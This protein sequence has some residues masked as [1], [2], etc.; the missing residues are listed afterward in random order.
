MIDEFS[1]PD[2]LLVRSRLQSAVFSGRADAL[3]DVQGRY[4]AVDTGPQSQFARLIA[5]NSANM[6]GGFVGG[7]NL[8]LVPEMEQPIPEAA[9]DRGVAG[10]K[11]E[12]FKQVENSHLDTV[13]VKRLPISKMVETACQGWKAAL[14]DDMRMGID[15]NAPA[16]E[17]EAFRQIRQAMGLFQCVLND[18]DI[19]YVDQIGQEQVARFRQVMDLLN[20]NWGRGL[21]KGQSYPSLK[22]LLSTAAL[23]EKK[24][25]TLGLDISTIRR[26]M[27]SLNEGFKYLA[28]QGFRTGNVD[29]RLLTPPKKKADARVEFEPLNATAQSANDKISAEDI[30]A[31]TRLPLYT[32]CAGPLPKEMANPGNLFFHCGLTWIPLLLLYTGA[33]RGEISALE[34]D[35]VV[36][37]GSTP[38]IGIR[39][40]LEG[41]RGRGLKNENSRR[42][43]PLH[44]ELLRLGFLNYAVAIKALGHKKLFPDIYNPDRPRQDM[45]DV[46]Y[47]QIQ[48]IISKTPGDYTGHGRFFHAMRATFSNELKQTGVSEE[49][50]SEIAGQ[51]VGGVNSAI[52]TDKARVELKSPLV[53]KFENVTGHLNRA[54]IRLLPWVSAKKKS[55][56]FDD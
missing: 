44:S 9:V 4:P 55:P 54:E 21:R 16:D 5:E 45:G 47:K 1:L 30:S 51:K 53:E 37:E 10:P 25:E 35:D 24:G 38:Y 56:W 26:H 8:T 40:I 33:R 2:T 50:R 17:V 49:F 46:L 12:N 20:T 23:R 11:T 3:L 18:A 39:R 28:A 48:K 42:A 6:E 41:R 31:F 34:V 15:L 29:V 27:G 32:G 14:P 43:I 19:E 52:Y 7:A 13:P 22:Q 36:T